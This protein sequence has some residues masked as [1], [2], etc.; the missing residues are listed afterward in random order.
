MNVFTSDCRYF[1]LEK[2]IYEKSKLLSQ[3]FDEFGNDQ[4][5]PLPNIHS[6][7]LNKIIKYTTE[8]VLIQETREDLFAIANATDYLQ[9]DELLDETC[10]EIAELLKG[11]SPKEIRSILDIEENVIL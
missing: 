10:K 2:A 3:F 9:M 11:K 5:V 4:V 1:H 8:D 7:I 6:H